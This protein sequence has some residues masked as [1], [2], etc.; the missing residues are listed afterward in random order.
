MIWMDGP[1]IHVNLSSDYRSLLIGYLLLIGIVIY[2]KWRKQ[3]L[4]K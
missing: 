2:R 4:T 1:Y 3:W